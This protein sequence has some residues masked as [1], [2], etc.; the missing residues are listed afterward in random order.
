MKQFIGLAIH[1]PI[2]KYMVKVI[3]SIIAQLMIYKATRS[4]MILHIQSAR[5]IME[6]SFF[7]ASLVYRL[8]FIEVLRSSSLIWRTL[9]LHGLV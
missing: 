5:E 6:R 8:L 9:K 3:M 7:S 1:I 2:F 4:E